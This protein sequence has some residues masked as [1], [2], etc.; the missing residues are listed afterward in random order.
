MAESVRLSYEDWKPIHEARFS[1]LSIQ[2]TLK[3]ICFLLVILTFVSVLA[4]GRYF[5]TW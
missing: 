2:S 3:I 1:L 5:G 4:C